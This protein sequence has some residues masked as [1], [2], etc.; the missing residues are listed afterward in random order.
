MR[1]LLHDSLVDKQINTF[2]TT[3]MPS[4]HIENIHALNRYLG[5]KGVAKLDKLVAINE[6]ES[7]WDKFVYFLG[8]IS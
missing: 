5:I 8:R 3:K 4:Q 7:D 6:S 2:D 1:Q